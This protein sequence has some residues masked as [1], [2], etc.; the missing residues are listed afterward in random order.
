VVFNVERTR[1]ERHLSG[2]FRRR[3]IRRVC[4]GCATTFA[5]SSA[6]GELMPENGCVGRGEKNGV[7]GL[8][9]AICG[10]PKISWLCSV[11]RVSSSHERRPHTLSS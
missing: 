10:K 3:E 5:D 11:F 9:I 6:M 1:G 7:S 8:T 2:P 4:E